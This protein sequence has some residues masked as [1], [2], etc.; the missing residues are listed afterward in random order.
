MDLLT[1]SLYTQNEAIKKTKSLFNNGYEDAKNNETE[2][3]HELRKI[4][5]KI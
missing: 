3:L 4:G 2:I 5:I 1:I